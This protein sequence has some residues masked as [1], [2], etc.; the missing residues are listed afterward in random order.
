[1]VG[2]KAGLLGVVASTGVDPFGTRYAC[3]LQ[4]TACVLQYSCTT[5]NWWITTVGFGPDVLWS[6]GG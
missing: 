3:W 6:K 2:G 5:L 4:D 1:M